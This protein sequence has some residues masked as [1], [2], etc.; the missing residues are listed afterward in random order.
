MRYIY[1]DTIVFILL[2]VWHQDPPLKG[3]FFLGILHRIHFCLVKEMLNHFTDANT[4]AI[5]CINRL[6]LIRILTKYCTK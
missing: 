4:P 3:S 1:L 6:G 2:V 5:V